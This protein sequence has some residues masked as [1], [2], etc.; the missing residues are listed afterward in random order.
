MEGWR[1][2]DLDVV[3]V[4]GQ[5]ATAPDSARRSFTARR[6]QFHMLENGPQ[7]EVAAKFDDV[8]IGEGYEV[9]L[10]RAISE[11][12]LTGKLTQAITLRAALA[13]TQSTDDAAEAWR[14]LPARS[15]L[16]RSR[17]NPRAGKAAIAAPS[18]LTRPI[19][20]KA[21]SGRWF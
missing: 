19:A 1:A 10:G 9:R 14:Q 15:S 21:R 18:R 11:A 2:F 3:A 20:G 4:K 5:D 13:G 7:L 16:I 6:M 12:S 17:C 8:T